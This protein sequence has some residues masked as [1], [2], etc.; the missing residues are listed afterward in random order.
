MFFTFTFIVFML[1]QGTNSTPIQPVGQGSFDLLKLILGF[2]TVILA[3][4]AAFFGLKKSKLDAENANYTK[5][6]KLLEEHAGQ[7]T[8][9]DYIYQDVVFLGPR[10]SGKTSVSELWVKPFTNISEI[11]ASSDWSKNE[12]SVFEY[13]DVY[14]KYDDSLKIKRKYRKVIRVRL[15]DYPGEDVYRA[16]AIKNL[17]NLDNA[18]LVLFFD[19]DA[20]VDGIKS[21]T[22]NNSYYSL[23]FCESIESIKGITTNISKVI[24]A[25]NKM[26]LITSELDDKSIKQRLYSIN[27]VSLDRISSMF[28]GKLETFYI[29]A[30]N[31]TKLISLLG[32]VASS[33]LP[34]AERDV[35]FET[36]KKLT[37]VE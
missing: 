6:I 21:T 7:M 2:L 15:L 12:F 35:F 20:D 24:I 16:R 3:I 5:R 14:E 9:L 26:D 17:P 37:D 4:T 27:K 36:L 28:S 30:K 8:T 33:K 29:S 11:A 1:F 22:K 34:Q 32:S 13:K 19:I 31:N 10:Q 23:S 18:A 25:F